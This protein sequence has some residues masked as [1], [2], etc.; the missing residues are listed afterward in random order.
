MTGPRRRVE[1]VAPDPAWG[2][3]AAA[4]AALLAD[5]LGDNL[6]VVHHIGSTAIPGIEAKPVI[7]L[8]PV[9]RDLG[10]VDRLEPALVGAGFQWRGENGIAGRRF[11]LKE[12]PA[13]GRRLAHI[14]IFAGGSPEIERHLAFR[15]Y[16]RAHPAEAVDYQTIKQQ[17]ARLHP[18]DP[19]AYNDAKND[20]IKACE[21]RALSWRRQS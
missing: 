3:R 5:I 15:D 8:L 18:D 19:L 17:A 16:L 14:H 11:C 2:D 10:R 13:S 7:D 6:I 20:W 4:E 21:Q 12:D 9:V 1:L